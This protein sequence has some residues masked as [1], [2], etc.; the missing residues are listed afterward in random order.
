MLTAR[1]S[2]S[3][4]PFGLRA[5]STATMIASTSEATSAY[6]SSIKVAGRWVPSS[7]LTLDP[8]TV[9]PRF[10]CSAFSSQCQYRSKNGWSRPSV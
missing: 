3:M 4:M 9:V 7:W 10:P 6:A 5:A 2:L 8:V 1:L